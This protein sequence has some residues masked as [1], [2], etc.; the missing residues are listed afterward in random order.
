MKS[1][2]RGVAAA[3]LKALETDD[4]PFGAAFFTVSDYPL[5]EKAHKGRRPLRE[6]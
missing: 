5:Q 3:E 4:D 1:T 6:L 2:A